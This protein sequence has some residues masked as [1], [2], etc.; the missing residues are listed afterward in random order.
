MSLTKEQWQDAA[1]FAGV[2]IEMSDM[3][4]PLFV[5][6]CD[7]NG[8]PWQPLTDWS[9]FG[10]LWVRLEQWSGKLTLT[11]QALA[12]MYCNFTKARLSGTEQELM[13]AGCELGAAIGK[14]MRGGK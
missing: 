14:A 4:V 3:G 12:V 11:S 6:Q 7:K 13:Q 9:D 1:R 8:Y 2:E 10:P 5:S